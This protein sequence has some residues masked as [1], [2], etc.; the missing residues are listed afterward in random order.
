MLQVLGFI[1]VITKFFIIIFESSAVPEKL[2]KYKRSVKSDNKN[3]SDITNKIEEMCD[4]TACTIIADTSTWEIY[5][6][7]VVA[8]SFCFYCGPLV[9]WPILCASHEFLLFWTRIQSIFCK[10]SNTGHVIAIRWLLMALTKGLSSIQP[11]PWILYVWVPTEE[12]CR[13]FLNGSQ[14]E[15]FF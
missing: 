7:D 2:E 14:M 1:V 6:T 10:L 9:C 5:M 12:S 4:I 11:G 3:L 13:Q 8:R 15:H